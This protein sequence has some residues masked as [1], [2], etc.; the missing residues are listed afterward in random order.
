MKTMKVRTSQVMT[1]TGQVI[2][3]SSDNDDATDVGNDGDGDG[4]V[5]DGDGDGGENGEWQW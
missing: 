4:M 2:V 3:M 1:K 5:V